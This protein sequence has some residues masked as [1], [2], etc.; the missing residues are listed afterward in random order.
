MAGL[1]TVVLVGLMVFLSVVTDFIAFCLLDIYSRAKGKAALK[2]AFYFVVKFIFC[3]P[4]KQTDRVLKVEETSNNFMS[5]RRLVRATAMA[6]AL[7]GVTAISTA[8]S[9]FSL[10]TFAVLGHSLDW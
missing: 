7:K 9:S 6:L 1:G 2:S 4:G 5:T 10:P 8:V 3:S